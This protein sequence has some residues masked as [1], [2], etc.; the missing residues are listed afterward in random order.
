MSTSVSDF[1]VFDY[2]KVHEIVV[3][4]KRMKAT[5]T[6]EKTDGETV[7][8]T[9]IYAYT[10]K[11]FDPQNWEDRNLAS[12]MAAQVALNYG[13]FCKEIIFEGAYD[14]K[15]Q[16][17]LRGAM[18]NTSREIYV[19]KL[20][21]DNEFLRPEFR[22]L[23]PEKKQ[24]Y[25]AA[26]LTFKGEA[27]PKAGKEKI[28][29]A[30]ALDEEAYII[31][32]SG[33]KDSLLSYG[34]LNEMA[35]AHPV[36]VNESGRHWYTAYNAY[37]KMLQ[38]EPNTSR[39]WCNCDRIFNWMVRQMPFIRENYQ[40]I[41]ADIYPIR[42]WTV[43]VFLF[44]VLPLA[45]K[46]KVKNIIIGNE[47]DTTLQLQQDGITHY[48]ALYDQSKYFDNTL[49][50]YYDKKGWGFFQFSILR[51]LSELLILKILVKRYPDLQ[52]LQVSCHAAHKAGDRM[53]PCG[54]CEKCRRI[55]GMLK[56][57]EED[58]GRCGY[59]E[60]QIAQ[61]LKA[62]EG[63]SVKQLGSD[64]QQLF[65]LLLQKELISDNPHTRKLAK[66]N[67]EI[68]Q[69]R[70][71]QERSNLKDMPEYIR[72]PLLSLFQQY[73]EGAVRRKHHKWEAISLAELLAENI[74]YKFSSTNE[75]E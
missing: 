26:T 52:S 24:K 65:Y 17:F 35:S 13:L 42:L 38:T 8:N 23:T 15:D 9:L 7:S 66:K 60:E 39:V 51:S 56:A 74:P 46:R 16:S 73:S 22:N 64:A 70:F 4:P 55:V 37:H 69:L 19:H 62:L 41:R 28:T 40:N 50:R 45:R 29:S 44:G 36:Y 53:M 6:L 71:D 20:L 63:K 43:S 34:I 30:G 27:M 25:T 11:V 10:E 18:E 32:S 58:P 72:E 59:S 49:T 21:A 48:A 1:I 33:G 12:T 3:E 68:M 5:Y 47:Y 61:C 31:L 75:Q 67:P 14:D 54:K 2:L 57:L